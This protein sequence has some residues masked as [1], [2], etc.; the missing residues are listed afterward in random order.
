VKK[1]PPRIWKRAWCGTTLLSA[2]QRYP[3][4]NK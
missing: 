4:S 2:S 1:T 3:N